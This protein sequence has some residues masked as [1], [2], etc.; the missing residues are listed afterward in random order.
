METI[1]TI[2]DWIVSL[3][4]ADVPMEISGSI[5]ILIVLGTFYGC[6]RKIYGHSLAVGMV[7]RFLLCCVSFFVMFTIVYLIYSDYAVFLKLKG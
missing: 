1:E 7:C 5:M 4:M 3:V 2:C 6:E